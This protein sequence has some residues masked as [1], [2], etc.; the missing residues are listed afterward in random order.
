MWKII[1]KEHIILLYYKDLCGNYRGWSHSSGCDIGF[2]H[3]W[4]TSTDFNFES[5]KIQQQELASK[6]PA[7]I[8][9]SYYNNATYYSL[10]TDFLNILRIVDDQIL[11]TF[12]F[13][14]VPL[15]R[16]ETSSFLRR[17]NVSN[18]NYRGA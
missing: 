9:E 18:T 1:D 13:S 16:K 5:L 11:S 6:L 3:W 8:H 12:L 4:L 2:V 14:S 15:I 10:Q 17:K 7:T